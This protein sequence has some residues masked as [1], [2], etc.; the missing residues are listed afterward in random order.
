MPRLGL[1]LRGLHV[2]P[3]ED[4]GTLL[5]KLWGQG[6][7]ERLPA[8]SSLEAAGRLLGFPAALPAAAL[9]AWQDGIDCAG[10]WVLALEPVAIGGQA[11]RAVLQ[12][13]ACLADTEDAAL[14]AAAKA[15]FT[16]TPWQLQR[17]QRRW[18]L[19]AASPLDLHT[20][21]PD[22][23]WG[24]EPLVSQIRGSDARAFHAFLN[25]LQMLLAAHSVNEKRSAQGLDPWCYF[26]PW[27]EGSLP[28]E[29]P[30]T[31]WTHLAA[32]Q[33]ELLTA[34]RWL[35]LADWEPGTNS[36]PEALLWVWPEDWLFPE[37]AQRF[38]QEKSALS[39][40]RKRG[41]TLDM[42]TGLLAQAAGIEHVLLSPRSR[43]AF[44]R[45]RRRP[46]SATQ[47]GSW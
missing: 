46:G 41:G 9:L 37:T 32:Q 17:G 35:G 19:H 11:G 31:S 43:W 12:P 36:W 6:S 1:W 39:D 42:Y 38:A 23:V 22:T 34:G 5:P 3:Q 30:H 18:Y 10:D 16:G 29:R 13:V 24:H 45:G 25:E 15:H 27:G 20:P 21:D 40:F 4:L 7:A 26:W 33:E 8:E 28:Y 47:S 2:V 14:L 44:W